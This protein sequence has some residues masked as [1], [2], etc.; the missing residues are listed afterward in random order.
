MAKNRGNARPPDPEP[1]VKH[2]VVFDA[3]PESAGKAGAWISGEPDQAPDKAG[4]AEAG[5]PN[6]PSPDLVQEGIAE[7]YNAVLKEPLPDRLTSTV[8]NLGTDKGKG[9][10]EDGEG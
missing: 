4:V 6:G 2:G 8:E 10:G 3:A 9:N 5:S 7:L 1:D